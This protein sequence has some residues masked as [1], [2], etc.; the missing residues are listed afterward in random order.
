[1]PRISPWR[2]STSWQPAMQP[3]KSLAT[4]KRA[5]LQSVIWESSARI[6]GVDS[7]RLRRRMGAVEQ[8]NGPLDP[9]APVAEQPAPDA[10]RDRLAPTHEPVRRDEVEQDVVVVAG[11]EGHAFLGAGLD[12]AAQNVEGTVAV[13]GRDLDRDHVLQRREAAPEG[14]A[15]QDAADRRLQVETHQRNAGGRA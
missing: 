12:D 1:M 6:V 2:R 14:G 4:S 13:E 5:A 7:V 10:H 3:L 11:V 15:K 8:L 9:D